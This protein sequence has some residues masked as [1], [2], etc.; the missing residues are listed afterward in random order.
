LSIIPLN[1]WATDLRDEHREC[2]SPLPKVK[3]CWESTHLS[4]KD[5]LKSR[6][7]KMPIITSRGADSQGSP[8]SF[9]RQ[10]WDGQRKEWL[11]ESPDRCKATSC[12]AHKGR[13]TTSSVYLLA[14]KTLCFCDLESL[15]S[16]CQ[17]A[18]F[19]SEVWWSLPS[20]KKVTPFINSAHKGRC[21]EGTK[22][23]VLPCER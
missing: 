11:L 5:F 17:E 16:I 19:S 21:E 4:K 1:I 14:V 8:F 7:G 10:V 13:F 15:F 12:P 2:G 9:S 23:I 18:L 6:S 3:L 22:C 20:K